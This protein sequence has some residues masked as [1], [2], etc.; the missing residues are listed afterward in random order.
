MVNSERRIRV[1]CDCLWDKRPYTKK[2]LLLHLA[3]PKV[4]DIFNNSIPAAERGE[5]KIYKIA[6]DH[7]S[8]ILI[9]DNQVNN[10]SADSKQGGKCWRCD[11]VGHFA[12][13]IAV[14]HVTRSTRSAATWVIWKCVVTPNRTKDGTLAEA[15]V[16]VPEAQKE[17]PV[18][19]AE[20][21]ILRINVMYTG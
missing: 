17:N 12:K 11:K 19:D 6:M 5:P 7:I 4:R 8:L 1:I 18:V 2:A 10:V 13:V 21:E 3:G 9:P 20:E 14:A 15:R 16:V